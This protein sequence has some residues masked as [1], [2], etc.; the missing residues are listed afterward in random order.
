MVNHAYAVFHGIFTESVIFYALLDFRVAPAGQTGD[1]LEHT[2]GMI[3]ALLGVEV[4]DSVLV[5]RHVATI[6]QNS[7]IGH[8]SCGHR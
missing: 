1:T 8:G 5:R 4:E 6:I 2:E 3:G 7:G